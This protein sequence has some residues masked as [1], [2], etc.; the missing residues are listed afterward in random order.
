MDL[1]EP[2]NFCYAS[3]GDSI[4]GSF[5]KGYEA[6][7][8]ATRAVSFEVFSDS[9]PSSISQTRELPSSTNSRR[10]ALRLPLFGR[11]GRRDNLLF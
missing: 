4:C 10:D 7:Y 2:H 5:R 8:R 6:A 1:I 11:S 9:I 3:K